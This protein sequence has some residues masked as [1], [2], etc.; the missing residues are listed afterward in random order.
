MKLNNSESSNSDVDDVIKFFKPHSPAGG[1]TDES[2]FRLVWAL[3]FQATMAQGHRRSALWPQ[4]IF[5]CSS[6]DRRHLETRHC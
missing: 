5:R 3:E 2:I 6:L 1:R 4:T